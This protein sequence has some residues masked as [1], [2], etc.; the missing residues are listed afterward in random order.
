MTC[1]SYMILLYPRRFGC[2]CKQ[3]LVFPQVTRLSLTHLQLSRL[4]Y[5]AH[6]HTEIR[7]QYRFP[8]LR[9]DLCGYFGADADSALAAFVCSKLRRGAVGNRYCGGSLS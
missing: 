9:P 7:P 4:K 8:D 6:D 2:K 3:H 5:V 1:Y